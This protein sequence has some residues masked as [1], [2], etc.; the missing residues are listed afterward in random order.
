MHW[1]WASNS[2]WE[3]RIGRRVEGESG[4]LFLEYPE[5]DMI[6]PDFLRAWGSYRTWAPGTGLLAW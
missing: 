4:Y 3:D 5:I 2:I 1:S 6:D